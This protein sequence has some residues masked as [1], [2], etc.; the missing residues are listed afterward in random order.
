M[1]TTI[2]D[3]EVRI[4]ADSNQ[5]KQELQ[6]VETQVG[7]AFNVNPIN[8][9]STS[10]DSVTG[11]VGSLVSKFT[12]IAGI[13][14]GGFG[15][16][17]MIEGSVKAGEAVYQLSQRYQITTKEASEMNRI[18]KITGSDADTAAKTIMR[19]DKALSGNSNEGKKAQE[20]LKLFGV[21]L[22][23]ANG[24]M[25]PINQQLEE[26]AKGYKAAADAGYGQEYVMN[27]LGVRG[28][29]LI[30]VLQNYNE[31]AEVASKVKGIGLNPEEMHKASLQLKEMELQFGQ[32]KLA[33][34]AAITPLVMELLPQLLPYLQESAVWINKNKN[35]IASTA[36]TLVQIVALY[37]SIKIA[38]KAAAAVNA[39]VSTVKNSQSPMGLD[40]A[41]L[42]RAQEA[43]IN[44]ALRDNERVYAQMRREAI[45]TAN[46]QKLSAEETS[47]FLA[48]EFSKISIKATQSAEQIRAAMTIGFQGVRAEAA[49]SSIAV[50]RSILSTG[51][52]AEESANLHVASNVRK[53]ESD[54]AVVASQGKVGVAAT[55]A[56]TKAV[57]ASATATAAATANIEKNAVLAASYEGVGVRATTAGAVAVSAAGR[58][59]GAVT[60]LTRAVWALA[61]GW[62]GVA[63]AVGFALY[64]MG[65]A[66]KAEAEFQHA[67]EVTLMDKGKKYH[68]AK[69]REGKV[70]FANDSAGY[71]EVPE[72][73][74]NKYESYVSAQ[75]KASADAALGEIK[76]EQAKMQAELATQM[77][78]ISNIGDSISK[79]S[80]T[81]THKDTS[82]AAETV[83]FMINQGIDPRIAFGMA[84]GNMLESGGNT[85]NLNAKAVNPNGGAF[86]IQQWLLD[87]KEDLFNFAKQNHS[88]PY[89]I[90]TQ[91]AFQVYEMLYGKEKD[92]YKK[93]LAELGN[94]QDVGLAAKLVDK[95]ITRS[96]GTEDIRSQKA[97]NAQLLYKDM[98]GEGGLT[99]AD[100]LRRQKSIDDAKK[101]L[102]NLE[103][104]LKQSITGEI[105]TS[106]ESEIQKIEED[107]RK[108]SEAIKK[109]KDVSDTIDT[110]N[111]EKLLDQFKTVEVDKVNKK[112]Q[113]QRDKLKLDTAKTNAEIL[114]NYKDLA[115]QQFIV[116]KNE[117]DREREERLKSVAKQKDDAEA[118][119]QVEEWYTAK[120]KALVT[121]RETAER[122]S[123]D[124]AV[125][126]AISR[127]DTNRLQQLTSS[128]DAKQYRDWEGD[129][130]K[131]Q[132]FYKLWEQG[133]MSMSA[134]TA[135]AAES[136]ASGLS[137]IF[138]NLAT[139][140]T[141]VKDLTQNMGKLILSTVVNIIAKIAAARLAAALLGQSLGV[142]APSSASGGNVQKLTM[143][144]F[145]NSAIARMPNIPTYKFASGGVI[146]APVMSLMGEG[147]DNEAVLPLNQNTFANL[148]RNIANTIGGG[149]VMVNVNNYTNSKVT[150]TEETSNGDIKTQIVNIVI[151]EIA[152]N[153]N[154]SQDIL[155]QLIGG[156]R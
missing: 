35:E 68:L 4:G 22:T 110:S 115:E 102:K 74:R 105:G 52:A 58:A 96:E 75:K 18:L 53:V 97:A 122:E 70:V 17:S 132:T 148:G 49:E 63:A 107:V 113:E 64:S 79:T 130:A 114:G 59:M 150:V 29:A 7:K 62:L 134:A 61:G 57:E 55:V 155:K 88:D 80:T 95:W 33:S 118:K 8:E 154:G 77:Q 10:V 45:K 40:T 24:K 142:R 99:G 85:K 91:Q 149:P 69:N 65:Q 106:Y 50:N 98:K 15:L 140:I 129:T 13:M 146:T 20:T 44:K 71:V 51:V 141:S 109:I 147:K 56:G 38:K 144:G 47:A 6:K 9:F 34:S 12:A 121:E 89:D 103:G 100:I 48:Q 108:K 86:G 152:S 21:S 72:R 120:Y 67:N 133:N 1:G 136:F 126:L 37:E 46:Q 125:K 73:L 28:L 3:L 27:T 117:L 123:Y 128:K 137:S 143:Q 23:D 119:A 94:S 151:E 31:A 43:Q 82:S 135:E 36:K 30:S 16:T 25:L 104:E 2:A 124:K 19:L 90:H 101:D 127:H 14:A 54:M 138:S 5:F 78:N 156:R 153:R 76:A 131:L 139:D 111:A 83:R 87:R 84:G 93:A 92:N 116:S 42:T 81:T 112:L 145:V 32:L 60:T 26:L 39:V 41:E 66:N 11:R